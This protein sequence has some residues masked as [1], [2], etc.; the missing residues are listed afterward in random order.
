MGV[1]T[2]LM[3]F[4]FVFAPAGKMDVFVGTRMS[5]F[6]VVW[7]LLL[8]A[9]LAWELWEEGSGAEALMLALTWANLWGVAGVVLSH[10]SRKRRP[11]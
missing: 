4:Y 3:F 11:S 8:T 9:K 10:R 6:V 5:I 2:T 7:F 1:A